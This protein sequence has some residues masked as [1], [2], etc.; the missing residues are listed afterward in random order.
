MG[1]KYRL[2]RWIRNWL[3]EEP[4]RE[5]D[6]PMRLQVSEDLDSHGPMRISIHKAAG[7]LI[8]ETRVYDEHKDRHHQKLHI[9]THDQDLAQSLSKILT[10]ESLRV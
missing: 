4:E 8:I 9:V 3:N 1:M 5:Q 7:G 6:V 10:M 2:K